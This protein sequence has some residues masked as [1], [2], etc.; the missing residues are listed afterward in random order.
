MFVFSAGPER[1]SA[2]DCRVRLGS[3]LTQPRSSSSAFCSPSLALANLPAEPLLG[4][5]TQGTREEGNNHPAQSHLGFL[6]RLP[7]LEA[8]GWMRGGPA[9]PRCA[10]GDAQPE[11]LWPHAADGQGMKQVMAG[12]R[13]GLEQGQA[14]TI[15]RRARTLPFAPPS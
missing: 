6:P 11:P 15:P 10:P 13:Q 9:S 2:W 14:L 5:G 3:S 1:G 7:G 12:H 4:A 8:A